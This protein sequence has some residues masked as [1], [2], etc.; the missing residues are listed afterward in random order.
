MKLGLRVKI[1]L[2]T[3]GLTV[4]ALSAVLTISNRLFNEAYLAALQSRSTAIAQGLKLQMDRILQLGIRIDSLMGF[5]KQCRSAADNY[6]GIDFAVV[7]KPDG[8]ILFSSHPERTGTR[9]A[10]PQLVGALQAAAETTVEYRQNGTSGY[11]AVVPILG[12]DQAHV[13]NVVIGLSR[14]MVDDKLREM[15]V[16]VIGVGLLTLL[17]GVLVLVLA[18]THYISRP[19]QALIDSIEEVRSDTSH[20]ERRVAIDSTDELGTLARAFNGLMQSLQDTTVSKSSLEAAYEE[21]ERYRNHLEDLIRERTAAL[22][23]A[24]EAA[25]TANIAKTAFLANMSHEIRTPLNA[26]TGMAYL[27]RQGGATAQQLEKL[28]KIETASDHLLEIINAILDI[29][30]IEAGKCSLAEDAISVR[31]MIGNVSGMIRGKAQAKGL[32]YATEAG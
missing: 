13:G 3:V 15:R 22:V 7:A 28:D 24:K 19:V 32:T 11:G 4:A 16:A 26:I 31:G 17:G 6:A 29:S 9:I 5:D 21:L 8:T 30:K 14:A 20:L 1:L 2:I 25:E 10:D 12:P 18:V 23:V 27:L